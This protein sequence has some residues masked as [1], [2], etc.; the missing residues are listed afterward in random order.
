MAEQATKLP[1]KQETPAAR[2]TPSLWQPFESLRD[3]VDRIFDDFTR[4]FGRWP[5]GRRIF[6]I[7]PLVRYETSFGVSA[8]VVDVV[9]KEKEYQISAELPGLD[10]KDVE[11][12]VADDMLTIKGEKKEEKEEKAKNY[13][14]SERRYGAFQR[15]FQLPSGVDAEKIEANFQ[16]GVLTVILPKTPEAQKKEKKIAIKAK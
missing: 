1:V 4:G 15:S 6:D 13:Y 2:R 12:G 14:V 11:V 5:L 9:E 3:E 8:P 16:K 7:E 10:E